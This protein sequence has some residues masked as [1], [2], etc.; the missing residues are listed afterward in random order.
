MWVNAP[1]LS[2]IR[3]LQIQKRSEGPG[4]QQQGLLLKRKKEK[5]RSNQEKVPP[6]DSC[7][8]RRDGTKKEKVSRSAEII[9]QR[10]VRHL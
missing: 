5:T 4:A 6:A 8:Q 3:K 1:R 7:V 2:I 9:N 10:G